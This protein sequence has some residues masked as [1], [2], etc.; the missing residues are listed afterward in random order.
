MYAVRHGS[1]P[2]QRVSRLRSERDEDGVGSDS[3]HGVSV[4]VSV[5]HVIP[6]T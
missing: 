5:S 1:Q 6:L 4:H 3:E 2:V